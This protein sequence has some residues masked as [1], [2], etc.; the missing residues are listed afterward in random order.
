MSKIMIDRASWRAGAGHLSDNN[1]NSCG[2]GNTR[3]L[4]KEGYSCCLGFACDQ[5]S[6]GKINI[7][8]E[9]F[10]Q[11]LK[12]VIEPLT[13]IGKDGFIEDTDLS[14]KAMVINDNQTTSLIEKEQLLT[15]LFLENNLELEFY[16]EYPAR[17][18]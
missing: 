15:A 4:N 1:L 9:A 14:N 11:S 5:L 10:P 2:K 17:D 18:N 6:N 7:K 8:Y 3:L 12:S 13:K 16:G